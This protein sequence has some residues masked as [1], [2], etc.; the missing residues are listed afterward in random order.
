MI[1]FTNFKLVAEKAG[2]KCDSFFTA[3][4]FFKIYQG[5]YQGRISIMQF[6]NYVMRKVLTVKRQKIMTFQGLAT[7]NANRSITL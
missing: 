1:N 2:K 3:T 6:F 4:T 7:T 5:D